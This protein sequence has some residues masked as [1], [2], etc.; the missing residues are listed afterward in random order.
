MTRRWFLTQNVVLA[1]RQGRPDE[2]TQLIEQ[3]TNSGQ[4]TAATFL[5]RGPSF[6]VRRAFG[7]AKAVDSLFL[8]AS[9]TKPM[10]ATA[11][12]VLADRKEV[13]LSDPVQRFI[14]EFKGDGREAVLIKHLLTHT[15]GL[16]DMLPE[17]QELRKAHAPLSAF[18]DRTCRTPLLF[19]P[20]SELRYQSMGI[21]LV[22]AIISR[23]GNQPLPIFAK[24]HVFG[25]L[26]M[27]NT[28]IGLG[29]RPILQTMRCQVSNQS[30]WDWNS[31]YWRNLGSPWGGAFSHVDDVARFLE[32]FAHPDQRIVNIETATTMIT[33]QTEGLQNRWGLGWMLNNNQFGTGCSSA[34]FG[35]SGST[36]TLC[37]LDPKSHVSF[38]LLTTKPAKESTSTLLYPTSNAVSLWA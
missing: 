8:L 21:L 32:Y 12:M 31:P 37:W 1:L 7:Q 17:D 18:V 30:D 26:G 2:A 10:T 4:V 11:L 3:Q 14:P 22:G 25:P 33:N 5:A 9:I 35:H 20:G 29:G 36:G 19:R 28:S 34:T 38:V 23:I 24:E 6:A 15:S 27:F 16:P 13:S